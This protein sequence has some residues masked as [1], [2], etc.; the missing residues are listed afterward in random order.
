MEIEKIDED[1]LEKERLEK[2]QL[3]KERFSA[4]S[5]ARHSLKSRPSLVV[6]A[7]AE[8]LAGLEVRND[9]LLNLYLLPGPGVAAH[10]GVTLLH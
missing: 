5:S 4:R 7:F 8:L 1:E 6:Q 9:L 10:A 2:E 3:E